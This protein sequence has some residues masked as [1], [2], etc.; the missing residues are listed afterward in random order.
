MCM[1]VCLHVHMCIMCV[2]STLRSQKRVLGPLVL[3]LQVAMNHHVS[4]GNQNS[5]LYKGN[6]CS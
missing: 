5:V 1:Y 2:P 3:E 6:R 4:A